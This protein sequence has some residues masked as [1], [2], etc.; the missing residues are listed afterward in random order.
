MT[1]Y[2]HFEQ[3]EKNR[4]ILRPGLI[5]LPLF[6]FL[7]YELILFIFYTFFGVPKVIIKPTEFYIA[8]VKF[9]CC[10]FFMLIGHNT[11]IQYNHNTKKL[12]K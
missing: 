12:L 5:L 3:N 6:F 1:W 7:M 8:L 10:T 9:K 2:M 4:Y 11:I